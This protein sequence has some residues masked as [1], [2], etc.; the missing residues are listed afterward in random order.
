MCSLK[1]LSVPKPHAIP[2]IQNDPDRLRRPVKKVGEDWEEISWEQ[3][4][5]EIAARHQAITA[6][7]KAAGVYLGNPNAHNYSSSF[8][9]ARAD[10]I[11]GR[12]GDIFGLNTG[13][14]PAYDLPEMG[15]R[16]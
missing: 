9:N 5:S 8:F 4:F 14:T 3:A 15:L 7:P 2:D 13:P 10:K 6:G 12:E 11:M 16:P 1:V